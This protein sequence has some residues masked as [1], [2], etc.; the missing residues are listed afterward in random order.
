MEK[1]WSRASRN[2]LSKL[3]VYLCLVIFLDEQIDH[4]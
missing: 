2:K 3:C 1:N 4:D